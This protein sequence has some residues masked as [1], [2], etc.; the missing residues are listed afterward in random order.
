MR[1]F[2][3]VLHTVC[4][5]A[6]DKLCVYASLILRM[7]VYASISSAYSVPTITNRP[8]RRMP[9]WSQRSS[10]WIATQDFSRRARL[11]SLLEARRVGDDD[12]DGAGNEYDDTHDVQR[13]LTLCKY[14]SYPG[15]TWWWL[16][17]WTSCSC[18]STWC[19]MFSRNIPSFKHSSPKSWRSPRLQPTSKR[20][21]RRTSKF[22]RSIRSY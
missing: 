12:D 5:Y 17:A 10:S 6:F 15:P 13:K 14:F 4:V 21:R 7:R 16:K 22:R 18:R 11:A 3:C 8:P 2:L 19:Q 9:L 20:G 1:Y